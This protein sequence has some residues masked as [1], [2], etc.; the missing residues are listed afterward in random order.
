MPKV[1]KLSS[2]R[3]TEIDVANASHTHTASDITDF[4]TNVWAGLHLGVQWQQGSSPTMT[5]KGITVLY[6]SLSTRNLLFPFIDRKRV[7]MDSSGN[8]IGAHLAS[9]TDYWENPETVPSAYVDTDGSVKWS[10][11]ET[12]GLNCMVQVPQF[13]YDYS[14]SS[15]SLYA[16]LSG[17]PLPG[18]PIHPAFIKSGVP[19]PF[20]YIGAFEGWKDTSNKLRSLPNKQPTTSVTRPNLITYAGNVGT[21]FKLVDWYTLFAEQLQFISDYATLNASSCFSGVTNLTYSASNV[22]QNTGRTLSLGNLSGTVPRYSLDNGATF[23]TGSSTSHF[24]FRGVENPYGNIGEWISGITA[25]HNSYCVTVE[26]TVYNFT[27]DY[28]KASGS[29][30][31]TNFETNIPGFFPCSSGGSP[32]T[33][34]TDYTTR[35]NDDTR[36]LNNGGCWCTGTSAGLFYTDTYDSDTD[37]N[38]FTGGRLAYL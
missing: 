38:N 18:C 1:L 35:G 27:L 33:Y 22:S 25:Y 13:R 12:N 37:S 36:A 20:Y 21:G 6:N 15:S 28:T 2:G 26:G 32:A 5:R 4:L 8:I 7:A 14:L 24:S 34:V 16:I 30:F 23:E 29:G 11:Y 3:I 9:N 10:T 31:A 17:I 19:Q